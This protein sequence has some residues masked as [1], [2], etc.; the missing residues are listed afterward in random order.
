LLVHPKEIEKPVFRAQRKIADLLLLRPARIPKHIHTLT[1]VIMH[2]TKSP[3]KT[4]SDI[5]Y[6]GRSRNFRNTLPYALFHLMKT[7]GKAVLHRTA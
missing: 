7:A 2:Q 4:S 3:G 6:Q 5:R 1:A